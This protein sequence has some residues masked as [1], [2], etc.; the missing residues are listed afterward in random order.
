MMGSTGFR[1]VDIAVGGEEEVRAVMD[2]ETRTRRRLT[3]EFRRMDD[4]LAASVALP[5]VDAVIRRAGTATRATT[6]AAAAVFTVGSLGGITAVAQANTPQVAP[7]ADL[8][9]APAPPALV[10]GPSLGEQERAA[11]APT[12]T[13]APSRPT[14]VVKPKVPV[15]PK[16]TVA[17]PKPTVK[18]KPKVTVQPK[19]PVT[20]QPD[21]DTEGGPAPVPTTTPKAPAG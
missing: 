17:K 4:E 11:Q 13:A 15:K 20:T 8:V 3:S 6:A 16:P 9:A 1:P 12:T 2:D 5:A 21:E 10:P 19:P 18:P 7:A 14:V